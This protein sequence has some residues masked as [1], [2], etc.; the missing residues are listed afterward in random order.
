VLSA[1]GCYEH[2]PAIFID[3]HRK[4]TGRTIAAQA[5]NGPPRLSCFKFARAGIIR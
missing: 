5:G 2:L 1:G 4:K 3:L